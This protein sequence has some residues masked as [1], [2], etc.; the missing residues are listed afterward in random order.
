MT[1]LKVTNGAVRPGGSE[2]LSNKISTE[3]GR[4][5]LTFKYF[6][7]LPEQLFPSSRLCTVPVHLTSDDL[8]EAVPGQ[9]EP[10]VG[11]HHRHLLWLADRPV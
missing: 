7:K 4:G 9:E 1:L 2:T 6:R 11:H 5:K 3:C 8:A 10:A